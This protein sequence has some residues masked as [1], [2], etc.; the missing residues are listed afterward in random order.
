MITSQQSLEQEV[1]QNNKEIFAR[2]VK[3]LEGADFEILIASA[4]FT[5]DE[6]FDIVKRKAAQHINIQ[7][8]IADNQENQKLNFED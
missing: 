5:D 2:I 6:L 1:L 4:W 3:E 7:L 8:I